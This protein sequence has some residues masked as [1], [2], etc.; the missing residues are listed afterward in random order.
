MGR[1]E[2]N[3]QQFSV[4]QADCAMKLG[5]DSVLLGAWCDVGAARRILD[6]GTGCGIV[7]LMSAQ[8]N[9]SAQIDAIE[10]DEAAAR[11]AAFNFECSKWGSRLKAIHADFLMFA[12]AEPYDAIVSNPPFFNSGALAPN[13]RRAVARHTETLPF[14]RLFRHVANLLSENG[15]FSMI[16]AFDAKSEVEFWAGECNLWICRR[17]GVRTTPEKPIRRYLWEFSKRPATLVE[18]EI[19]IQDELGSRTACYREL[20]RDFYLQDARNE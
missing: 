8:K 16:A 2:F 20:T 1:T 19:S 6:V 14:E 5:T 17:A 13:K 12:P 7:A 11:E 3:F 15:K 10:I 18:E 9:E 4:R